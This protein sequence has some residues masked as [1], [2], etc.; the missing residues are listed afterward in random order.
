MPV[1]LLLIKLYTLVDFLDQYAPSQTEV[2]WKRFYYLGLLMD[3]YSLLIISD[4]QKPL[5][6]KRGYVQKDQ[7]N[8]W[9]NEWMNE[10]IFMKKS[11]R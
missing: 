1:V 7:M 9:M 8:E 4:F 2:N 6:S 10:T 3:K 11:S 5:L